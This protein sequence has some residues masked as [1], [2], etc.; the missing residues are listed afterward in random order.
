MVK[1]MSWGRIAT[2]ALSLA[3]DDP[4]AYSTYEP[5]HR[6]DDMGFTSAAG[7][8]NKS[9]DLRQ[10]FVDS[11]GVNI[12]FPAFYSDDA[13]LVPHMPGYLVSSG[14]HIIPRGDN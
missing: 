8:S 5:S 4:K 1:G 7:T 13:K 11:Y 6:G 14:F 2:N 3:N 10:N 9:A 12:E